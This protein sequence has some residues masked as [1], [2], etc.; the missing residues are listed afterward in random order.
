MTAFYG[1]LHFC[2]AVLFC[3]RKP[4]LGVV[5]GGLNRHRENLKQGMK[6]SF[7]TLPEKRQHLT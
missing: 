1:P 6:L 3:I 2:A 5:S 4:P 7:C